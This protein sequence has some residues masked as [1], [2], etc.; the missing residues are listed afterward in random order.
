MEK[1]VDPA[2]HEINSIPLLQPLQSTSQTTPMQNTAATTPGN[3]PFSGSKSF[4]SA[5]DKAEPDGEQ[6]G[7]INMPKKQFIET[8]ALIIMV[9]GAVAGFGGYLYGKSNPDTASSTENKA[10]QSSAVAQATGSAT[11]TPKMTTTIKG[12]TPSGTTKT[13]VVTTTV[14]AGPQGTALSFSGTAFDT[15]TLSAARNDVI[16]IS[17]NSTKNIFVL[18]DFNTV[19]QFLRIDAD[20]RKGLGAGDTAVVSFISI[21]KHQV[22]VFNCQNSTCVNSVGDPIAI[23]MV[24]VK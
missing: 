16:T 18:A 9:V 2:T 7:D 21:G 14:D 4:T 5:Y 3:S 23:V 17:N 6:S 11:L 10:G 12:S 20:G 24:T 22:Q 8:I 13:T 1:K 19:N 15:D